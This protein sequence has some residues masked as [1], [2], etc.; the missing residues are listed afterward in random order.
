VPSGSS[1]AT[2]D[3]GGFDYSQGLR[4]HRL[5]AGLDDAEHLVASN[6]VRVT[7]APGR[8]GGASVGEA[9][10]SGL[11]GEA[12][13][14]EVAKDSQHNNDDDDD[15]KPGRHMILSSGVCRVY[16]RS[17]Q[18][19]RLGGFDHEYRLLPAFQVDRKPLA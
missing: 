4:P 1:R 12:P 3:L 16:A 6:G 9:R 11:P 14:A 8:Y 19:E 5:R 2:A 7:G 17:G 13:S 15:P 18:A 10:R